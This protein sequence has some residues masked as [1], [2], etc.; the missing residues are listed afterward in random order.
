MDM[1][2]NNMAIENVQIISYDNQGVNISGKYTHF[3]C[4]I[5][6]PNIT[7]DVLP[8]SFNNFNETCLLTLEEMLPEIIL[9]G[10]GAKQEF[11]DVRSQNSEIALEIMDTGS[12]CRVFN[13]LTTEERNVLAALY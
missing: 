7:T 4:V 11:P 3:P 6:G 8:S 1:D 10:T 9:L 2:Q 12:A 5:F 13:I